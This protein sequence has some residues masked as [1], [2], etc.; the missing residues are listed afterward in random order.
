[1]EELFYVFNY[2]LILIG[3]VSCK[4][5]LWQNFMIK[6]L[7]NHDYHFLNSLS[8]FFNIIDLQNLLYCVYWREKIF[9]ALLALSIWVRSKNSPSS[10]NQHNMTTWKK[11]RNRYYPLC[12]VTFL[13]SVIW[14]NVLRKRE[15]AL[16]SF[17]L[18]T[19]NIA[20]NLGTSLH[21]AHQL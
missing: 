11:V 19:Q 16:Y 8:V 18:G 13:Y 1:M 21:Q 3:F 4:Y 15:L 6:V 7:N 20:I 10:Q 9:D 14:N 12:F 17:Y 5:I 2:Y